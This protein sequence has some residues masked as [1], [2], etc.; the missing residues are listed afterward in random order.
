MLFFCSIFY[1][2]LF[3]LIFYHLLVAV[4]YKGPKKLLIL[5]IESRLMKYPVV[6]IGHWLFCTCYILEC[7][8]RS[9]DQRFL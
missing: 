6:P 5:D 1:V 3:Y 9:R 8:F 2:V 7:L 4:I